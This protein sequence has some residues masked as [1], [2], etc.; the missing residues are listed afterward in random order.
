LCSQV[1]PDIPAQGI[2]PKRKPFDAAGIRYCKD[3]PAVLMA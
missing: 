3:I 1:T 2:S